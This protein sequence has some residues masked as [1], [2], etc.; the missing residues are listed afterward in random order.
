MVVAFCDFHP[1]SD[2]AAVPEPARLEDLNL[3]LRD[4]HDLAQ[5]GHLPVRC[6]GPALIARDRQALIG[7]LAE[8]ATRLVRWRHGG[9]VGPLLP[10]LG[11]EP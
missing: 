3:W 6:R 1:G 11:F 5:G 10:A 4:T 9:R 8:R 7:D 2:A